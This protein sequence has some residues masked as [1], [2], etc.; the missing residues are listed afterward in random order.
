MTFRTLI[1][2]SLLAASLG[3]SEA[4]SDIETHPVTGVVTY[5]GRPESDVVLTFYAQGESGANAQ[6]VTNDAGEFTVFTSFEMGKRE[7]EG[8]LPGDYRITATK[9]DK[10]PLAEGQSAP[11]D[12]LPTKYARPQTSNLQTTIV[13]GETKHLNL[14]L[15]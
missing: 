7:Q 4:K 9:I 13:A 12:L 14:P 15:K 8:M 3:C 6:A 2:I 5:Q 10:S 11:K 1:A